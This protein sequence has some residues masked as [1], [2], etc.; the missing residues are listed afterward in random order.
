MLPGGTS[1]TTRCGPRPAPP[2]AVTDSREVEANATSGTRPRKYGL[3]SV[4][5]AVTCTRAGCWLSGGGAAPG[6]RGIGSQTNVTF[7][8]PFSPR[9][10]PSHVRIARA[11]DAAELLTMF[12]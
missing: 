12:D 5:T 1:K 7:V 9:D 11:R 10:V 2:P 3:P 4:P 8:L 6:V